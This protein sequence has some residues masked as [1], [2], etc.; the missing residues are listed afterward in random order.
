M[1]D[2]KENEKVVLQLKLPTIKDPALHR[3]ENS[4]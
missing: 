2:A 1:Q 4:F 3:F